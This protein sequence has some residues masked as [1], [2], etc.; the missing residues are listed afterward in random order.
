MGPVSRQKSQAIVAMK[1]ADFIA[2]YEADKWIRVEDELPSGYWSDTEQE[3]Y[4][5]FSQQVNVYV[6]NDRVGTAAYNRETK[7]WFTGSLEP[8]NYNEFDRTNVTHWQ[9]L[10][11]A[12][13]TK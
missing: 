13:K 5:K 4:K 10:P 1:R 3:Y 2:G 9:P 11:E 12:P 6:D 7:K 8:Q